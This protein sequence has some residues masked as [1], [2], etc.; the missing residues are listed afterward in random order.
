MGRGLVHDP[1]DI[2]EDAGIRSYDKASEDALHLPVD[3][4][5]VHTDVDEFVIVLKA[6][7]F[8]D[9]LTRIA[10]YKRLQETDM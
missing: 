1:T 3:L 5:I 9:E 6:P 10:L 4:H 8:S 2:D 7:P